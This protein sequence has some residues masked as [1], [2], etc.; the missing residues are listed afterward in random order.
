MSQAN[1]HAGMSPIPR[2]D[3][4]TG[5]DVELPYHGT[6]SK[7]HHLHIG[8]II[9]FPFHQSRHIR[10]NCENCKH[11]M[12]GL[13]GNST[14]TTL[15]SVLTDS[16]ENTITSSSSDHLPPCSDHRDHTTSYGGALSDGRIRVSPPREALSIRGEDNVRARDPPSILITQPDAS[17]ANVA[18]K[19]P[20][21]NADAGLVQDS[22]TTHILV[23]RT[24]KQPRPRFDPR[25]KA[26]KLISL[27]QR[28]FQRILRPQPVLQFPSDVPAP[29]ESSMG[30][31][32][33]PTQRDF[34]RQPRN[35]PSQAAPSPSIRPST[36]NSQNIELSSQP[37]IQTAQPDEP[38]NEL[39]DVTRTKKERLYVKRCEAT[40]KKKHIA[41]RTCYCDENCHCYTGA[42]RV[43]DK[44]PH[45]SIHGSNVPQHHLENLLAEVASSS[46]SSVAH[47]RTHSPSRQIAFLG[48]H[49]DANQ[50]QT[51]PSFRG[52]GSR[53]MAG[54]N[55]ERQ[56]SRISTSTHTS[57]ATTA[58]ESRS[59]GARAASR[60]SR[61]SMSFPADP[62]HEFIQVAERSRPAMVDY[63]R[64]FNDLGHPI[65]SRRVL[66]PVPDQQET[67]LAA[68]GSSLSRS[69]S[70]RADSSHASATSLSHLPDPSDEQIAEEVN[71]NSEAV[72]ALDS[73]NPTSGEGSNTETPRPRNPE[74]PPP[75]PPQ[76]GSDEVSRALQELGEEPAHA[77][78]VTDFAAGR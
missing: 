29:A 56:P 49:L 11:V 45:D 35:E 53:S 27:I 61:R 7:C 37:R 59:S 65:A 23:E 66:D 13:G 10:F 22:H 30:H 78:E 3:E 60:A 28:P 26:K 33:A 34:G 74:D 36:H 73:S 52:R 2:Q 6:C 57:Q 14:Q 32:E 46:R 8:T 76:P 72:F 19:S 47:L 64:G 4:A 48:A 77:T 17:S 71:T 70:D 1:Q 24:E 15:A 67:D 21:I 5:N 38:T 68:S 43:S 54:A 42:G 50:L 40:N 9:R 39:A 63:L 75:P 20:P 25:A 51:Q 12:F 62:F 69:L 55:E 31:V 58:V 44:S 41:A 18:P 16:G